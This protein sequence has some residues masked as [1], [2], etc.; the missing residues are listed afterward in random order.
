MENN[1]ESRRFLAKEPDDSCIQNELLGPSSL[2]TR[3]IRKP[4]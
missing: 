2:N 3:P 4:G 1:R